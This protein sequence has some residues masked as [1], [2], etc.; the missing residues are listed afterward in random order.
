[1]PGDLAD[2]PRF[3]A[4]R[5]QLERADTV[6]PDLAQEIEGGCGT[7]VEPSLDPFADG[8][9]VGEEVL[10][11]APA[12]QRRGTEVRSDMKT[13][14]A[15]PGE[16]TTRVMGFRVTGFTVRASTHL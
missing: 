4:F 5:Q 12:P 7:G 15:L 2:G 16:G 10:K 1:M 13:M 8:A 3:L 14:S 9:A 6:A 11:E